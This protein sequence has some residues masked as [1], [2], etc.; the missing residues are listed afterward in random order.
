[1]ICWNFGRPDENGVTSEQVKTGTWSRDSRWPTF[2][3]DCQLMNVNGWIIKGF[4]LF[5]ELMA[6]DESVPN[7]IKKKISAKKYCP[8]MSGDQKKM[9]LEPIMSPGITHSALQN[10]AYGKSS[11]RS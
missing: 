4:E 2:P 7:F 9:Y 6:E 8:Y 5:T 11:N 1:V 3:Y 10:N